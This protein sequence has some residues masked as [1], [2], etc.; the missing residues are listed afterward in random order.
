MDLIVTHNNA[1]FDALGAVIAAQK[2]YPNSKLLLPGSAEKSVR[3]FLALTKDKICLESEKTCDFSDIKKLV[4]VDTRH[5]S[6]IGKAAFLLNKNIEVHIYDHHPR[7]AGDIK[8]DLDIYEEAGA[9]ITILLSIIRK[10]QHV[11][12]SPLEATIMLIGIYEETGSLAYRTTTRADVD[13]VSFL[14]GRG[15][16]LQAVSSYLNRELT[17]SE[18]GFLVDLINRTEVHIVNGI[19]I[20]IASGDV[21]KFVGELAT[22]AHKLQ[23]VEN[24]PVLF[25]IFNMGTKIRVIARSRES[26]VD[27]NKIMNKLGGGGHAEAATAKIE[28]KTEEQVKQ[29]ILSILR[30]KIKVKIYAK[31]IM[32]APVKTVSIKKKISDTKKMFDRLNIRGAPC[33]EKNKIIGIITYSDIKKALKHRFG[34]SPVKGYMRTRVITINENTLL[35]VMQKIMFEKN[36]G[37]LPVLKK[38]RLVGIVTR[39][40]VLRRVH[41]G[42]F[43]IDKTSPK[44]EVTF[45]LSGKMRRMLPREISKI[46]GLIGRLSQEC[47]CRSFAVGGFVRDMLLGVKNFDIDIVLEGNT[48]EFSR[49]LAKKLNG[50]LIVHKKFGTSTVVTDWPKGVKKPAFAGSK[51]KIDL[52]TARRETYEKPAALPTVR[53]SSLK[54]DL[55]RRDFSINAMAVSLNKKDFGELTDFFGGLRDLKNKKIRVLH[56]ASFIDD[57]TRIFRAV[58]FEQRYSFKIDDYTE[59]LIRDAVKEK[60]FNK[61]QNQRIRDELLL[62]LK[63]QSPL[64]ALKRMRELHELRF[65]HKSIKLT[66]STEKLFRESLSSYKWYSKASFSKKNSDLYLVYLACLTDNLTLTEIQNLCNKFV[67]KRADI[68]KLRAYKKTSRKIL[69]ALSAKKD[70]PPSEI[71]RLLNPFSCENMLLLRAKTQNSLARRRIDCFMLKYNAVRIKLCGEDLKKIGL[72]AGPQF[73]KI[74]NRILYAKLDGKIKTKDDER[75]YLKKIVR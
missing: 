36:V 3:E 59:R 46:L 64:K 69:H 5:K 44:R 20:A 47:G 57:P 18:L 75:A 21:G 41:S 66:T 43:A 13:I 68:I 50:K 60:M 54:N 62:I 49:L 1:D 28:G 14:L 71:Y 12:I 70:I 32:A 34:H 17:E 7:M 26:R 72:K 16:N 33:V 39:T 8:G 22:I 25:A 65:I 11:N 67:F 58:R 61:T 51:L 10:K 9:T 63:E 27:V 56:D 38:G 19:N 55:L 2:L 35:H 42:L 30:T 23:E 45:N 48:A 31:D 53:F 73:K 4:I 40:D 74:L 29:T 37:R 15:A 52:A 24:H 6:R